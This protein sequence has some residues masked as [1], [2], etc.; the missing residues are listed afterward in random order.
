MPNNNIQKKKIIDEILVK[1][2]EKMSAL[3]QKRDKIVSVFLNALKEKKLEELKN[4]LKQ[5]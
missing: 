3:R 4:L 1:H 5:L 2:Q